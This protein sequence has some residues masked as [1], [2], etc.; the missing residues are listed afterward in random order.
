MN[1]KR[2]IQSHFRGWIPTEP[3]FPS[4]V[5]AQVPQKPSRHQAIIAYLAIFA[6]VFIAVFLAMS[7]TSALDLGINYATTAA[8]TAAVMAAIVVSLLL[9]KPNQNKPLTEVGKRA[10]KVIAGANVVMVGVFLGTY[11]LVNPNI[12][13]AEL[14]LA[15]WIVLLSLMFL[16]N[17]LL[18]RHFKKQSG[19]LEGV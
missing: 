18:F 7:V 15:L 13:S 3:S 12:G 1:I 16:V 9:R 8:A 2:S 14:T 10:A 6:G 4:A 11:F 19:L 5:T 17:N